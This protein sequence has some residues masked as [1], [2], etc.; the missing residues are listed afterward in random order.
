MDQVIV[1]AV[2]LINEIL[3]SSSELCS[4]VTVIR[5][6]DI[7]NDFNRLLE[8]DLA[9]NDWYRLFC[10]RLKR[11]IDSNTLKTASIWIEIHQDLQCILRSVMNKANESS[12]QRNFLKRMELE[13]KL[14]QRKIEFQKHFGERK[15]F[16]QIF[17]ENKTQ[18]MD[19]FLN[20]IS[21]HSMIQ[22]QNVVENLNDLLLNI[23][24]STEIMLSSEKRKYLEE[25]LKHIQI[26]LNCQ[27]SSID[28]LAP[29]SFKYNESYI[30]P[31][32]TLTNFLPSTEQLQLRT[33]DKH[34][35]IELILQVDRWIV[36]L[37]GSGSEFALWHEQHP[38]GTLFDYIGYHTWHSMSYC[39]KNN[40]NVLEEV[41]YHGH[42]LILLDGLDKITEIQRRGEIVNYIRQFL[43]EYV[44]T[45]SF[46]SAMDKDM[47]D[48]QSIGNSNDLFNEIHDIKRCKNRISNQIIVTSRIVGYHFHSLR[49]G[50]IS[51]YFI[52]PMNHQEANNFIKNWF[53]QIEQ[54]VFMILQK[55]ISQSIKTSSQTLWQKRYKTIETMFNKGSE[56]F[57]SNPLLLSLICRTVFQST[58]N[59]EFQS[60]IQVCDYVVESTLNSWKNKKCDIPEKVLFNFFIDL[61]C[62]LKLKSTSGLI[63][64]FD[65]EHLC[66]SSFI[67]NQLFD[68]R[69]KLRDYVKD[70]LVLLDS[71]VGII[72]ERDLQVYGFLHV[73]FQEYFVVQSLLR[74]SS[75]EVIAQ[76]ILSFTIDSQFRET[77]MLTFE[78]ISW[79]WSL[80]DYNQLCNIIFSSTDEYVI[81]FGIILFCDTL[82][83][84]QKL[85]SNS[86]LFIGLNNLLGHPSKKIVATYLFPILSKLNE[87]ITKEWMQIHLK[88]EENLR[89]FC[90]CLI[91]QVFSSNDKIY[92][93]DSNTIAPIIYQQ[94]WLFDIQNSSEYFIIDQTLRR[95][96][97]LDNFPNKIFTNSFLESSIHPLLLSIIIA[98]C[99]GVYFT[100]ENNLSKIYFSSEKMHRRSPVLNPIIDYLKNRTESHSVKIQMLIIEYENMIKK[101]SSTDYL[102]DIFIA[103]ICL[104]GL[105]QLLSYKKY[106]EYPAFFLALEKFKQIW[107]YFFESF[108]SIS[109]K[110][111][112]L[113][114]IETILNEFHIQSDRCHVKLLTFTFSCAA[115]YRKLHIGS[116]STWFKF[117][118]FHIQKFDRYLEYQSDFRH[119][120][121]ERKVKQMAE[122][123]HPLQTLQNESVFLLTFLPQ[124]LQPLFNYMINSSNDN[125]S[126]TSVLMLLSHCL[127]SLDEANPYDMNFHLAVFLLFPIL[128]KNMLENYAT[129][130][131]RQG[132]SKRFQNKERDEFYQAMKAQMF[133]I[134][135]DDWQILIETEYQRIRDAI[136][137]E[138]NETKDLQL[139]AASICLAR[140]YREKYNSS[141][142]LTIDSKELYFA[143]RNIFDP[144]LRL[145]VFSILLN[146]TAPLILTKEQRD[147]IKLE[148]V[149]IFESQLS[150]ISLSVL[151][152]L[153]IQYHKIYSINIQCLIHAI[154]EKFNN[155][156]TN[157]IQIEEQQAA[158]I[159]L[160]HFDN[161]DILNHLKKFAQRT[162]NLSDLLDFHS[163]IF[164]QYF[165]NTDSFNLSSNSRLLLSIMYLTELTFDSQILHVFADTNK[166]IILSSPLQNLKLITHEIAVWIT[167]YLEQLKQQDLDYKMIERICECRTIE[168]QA[169]IIVEKWL[170]YRMDKNLRMLAYYAALILVRDGLNVLNLNEILNEFF[171]NDTEFDLKLIIQDLFYVP[172][173]NPS[174][175][176]EVFVRLHENIRYSSQISVPIR[177]KE[178][179]EFIFDLEIERITSKKSTRPFL[180]MINACMDGMEIY[181]KEYIINF[182]STDH[183]MDENIK[184]EHI[185]VLLKWIIELPVHRFYGIHFSNE[186]FENIFTFIHNKQYFHIQKAV[187]IALNSIFT[188]DFLQET[189][190]LFQEQIILHIEKIIYSWHTYSEDIL[191]V[192]LLTYGNYVLKL[193]EFRLSRNLSIDMQNTLVTLFQTSSSE[194]ISI[195]TGFCLIFARE[196]N[197]TWKIILDWFETKQEKTILQRYYLHVQ[198]ALYKTLQRLI[199]TD[200]DI[201][202]HVIDTF[203]VDVYNYLCQK[204]NIDYLANPVPNY[205]KLALEF[206][207]KNFFVFCDALQRS[208]FGEET[209]KSEYSLYFYQTYKTI[210]RLVLVEL[211]VAFGVITRELIDML[212]LVDIVETSS[213]WGFIDK[214]AGWKYIQHITDVSDRDVIETIFQYLEFIISDKTAVCFSPILKLLVRFAQSEIVSLLEVHKYV[215]P[216]VRKVLHTEKK[217]SDEDSTFELLLDLSCIKKRSLPHFRNE[218]FIEQDIEKHFREKIC[219]YNKKS[220][221]YLRRNY[222]LAAYQ[223]IANE[224]T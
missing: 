56:L 144:V 211:Y 150:N 196:S 114:E 95:V 174:L 212:K 106:Q 143:V 153:F 100:H 37:G 24:G 168:K 61:A 134:Q 20:C 206:C 156:S 89:Q 94:L 83:N 199:M 158:F 125:A 105:S 121:I 141:S 184:H 145:T 176:R 69:K 167:E 115:A 197:P 205:I 149:D 160:Q 4:D 210:D 164:H 119:S 157:R 41:I 26:P 71:N 200:A 76:R 112:F 223:S 213:G 108:D 92:K 29:S 183:H 142:S 146:M 124:S 192:C 136:K 16:Y 31:N 74:G 45:P 203:V 216:L 43:N 131:C 120:L 78:W 178:I 166:E 152:L 102:I 202:L 98:V 220:I 116:I 193:N 53:L 215:T 194:L 103:L 44:R 188:S 96:V 39:D 154:G 173:K 171:T 90:N 107:F 177:C 85:P 23:Y 128:R 75:I 1:R 204:E 77:L 187:L 133:I 122:N 201:F 48:Y 68:N 195:R 207:S 126:P 104:Q 151:T 221:L 111:N 159:A 208:S 109:N 9:K 138:Q 87:N 34:L 186:F 130:L 19:Y 12:V 21:F 169:L 15:C 55:E 46:V 6:I 88:N 110:C 147:V 80:D 2:N 222:F 218:L 93:V 38:I 25:K 73:A 13:M 36:I 139:F 47:L 182:L 8:L 70:F 49:D 180:L 22:V 155:I 140:L 179:F 51:H 27:A 224:C 219:H 10:Q 127:S 62:Y 185:G 113:S 172:P 50:L 162:E 191:A 118:I 170:N 101:Y 60:R 132:E 81:P 64:A 214:N 7:R 181:L 86:I 11:M 40:Q 18:L 163:L 84:L 117:D 66:Y 57:T 123:L 165:L 42:A 190:V 30:T 5:F 3:E 148:I 28:M 161:I 67:R 175:L 32:N 189:H 33:I 52:S 217:W 65:M 137:L 135:S 17:C 82:E 59:I 198:L 79:K 97:S 99:G 58:N 91:T 209:F 14:E 63:D 54:N 129:I 72:A 35:N